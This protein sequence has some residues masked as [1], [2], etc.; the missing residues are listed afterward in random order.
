MKKPP[1]RGLYFD[2]SSC[3]VGGLV[4]CQEVDVAVTGSSSGTVLTV[5]LAI[6]AQHVTVYVLAVFYS[7]S[8]KTAQHYVIFVVKLVVT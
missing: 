8:G 4:R 2:M 1:K 7:L 3:S 5:S 6:E